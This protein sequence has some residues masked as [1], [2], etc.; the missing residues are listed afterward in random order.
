MDKIT[1]RCCIVLLFWL[2]IFKFLNAERDG[3]NTYKS[4]IVNFF[5]NCIL[6]LNFL[7]YSF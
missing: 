4:K 3:F 6:E 7:E 5:K 1:K 2:Q